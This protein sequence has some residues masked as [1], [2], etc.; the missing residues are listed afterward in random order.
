V[1]DVVNRSGQNGIAGR[2][3]HALVGKGFTQGVAST[4]SMETSTVVEYGST[5][6]AATAK[7][8]AGLLGGGA[9][10]QH[11][12][13]AQAGRVRVVLGSGFTMP[14]ALGGKAP[15]APD[16]AEMKAEAPGSNANAPS[17]L[18]GGSIPCV[19]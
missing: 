6:S 4:E 14:T 9:V 18:A 7:A 11:S 13:L 17:P 8:V 1:V 3:E 10:V 2:L 16:S 15:A 19:K 12:S 5:A